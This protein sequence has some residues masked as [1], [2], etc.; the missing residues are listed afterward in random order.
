MKN[1]TGACLALA[2]LTGVVGFF[3]MD[4][5]KDWFSVPLP[6]LAAALGGYGL[7]THREE[8]ETQGVYFAAL[9]IGTV[10]GFVFAARFFL[11]NDLF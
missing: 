3:P 2:I 9:V 8:E 5:W 6:G 4:G 10:L 1:L 7:F 11:G